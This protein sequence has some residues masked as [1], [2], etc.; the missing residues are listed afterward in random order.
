MPPAKAAPILIVG[1]GAWG[2]STAL[3]LHQ[4]GY[5]DITVFDRADAIPSPHSAAYDLNK[6]VR[7]EYEDPFYTELAL[8]SVYHFCLYLCRRRQS[9][10]GLDHMPRGSLLTGPDYPVI[11]RHPRLEN[12]TVRPLLPP[13]RI[14]RR[15][16]GPCSA[17]SNGTPA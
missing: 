8:V 10:S 17:E 1:A 11:G 15:H 9:G 12:T 4:A 3:H 2:L 7:A 14:H 16:D 13:D 6:I 5:T